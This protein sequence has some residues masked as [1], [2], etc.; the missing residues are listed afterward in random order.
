MIFKGKKSGIIHNITTEVDPGYEYNEKFR[1]GV[2]WY[3]M[4]SKDVC[5]SFSFRLKNE[6]GN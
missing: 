5:S 6:N 2:Q 3:V 1:G 4:E